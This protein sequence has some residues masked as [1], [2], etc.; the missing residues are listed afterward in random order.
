MAR[1]NRDILELVDRLEK[2]ETDAPS[3]KSPFENNSAKNSWWRVV[4]AIGA[5]LAIPAAIAQFSGYSLKDLWS[6]S[7][8]SFSV[9]VIVHGKDGKNDRILGGESNGEVVL[10]YGGTREQEPINLEGEA[11]FKEIPVSYLGEEV[12]LD[13]VHDQTYE[14]SQKEK[15]VILKKGENIYLEVELKNID[16]VYGRIIDAATEDPVDSVLVSYKTI[17]TCYSNQAGHY[18]LSIRKEDQEKFIKLNYYKK[19]YESIDWEVAPHI[20]Q[21]IDISLNKKQ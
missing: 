11:T 16:E 18:R 21:A 6:S 8:N 10:D 3:P 1:I 12:H 5:I 15:K 9:T 14:I 17:N 2:G 13:I 4:L 19:G 7:P 20:D